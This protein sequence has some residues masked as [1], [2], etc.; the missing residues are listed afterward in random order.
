MINFGIV[1]S[2]VS[3]L[4][5]EHYVNNQTDT[6]EDVFRGYMNVVKQSPVLMSQYI[7]FKNLE[8]KDILKEAAAK[9]IDDNINA[10]KRYSREEIIAENNKLRQFSQGNLLQESELHNAIQTLIIESVPSKRMPDVNKLYDSFLVVQESVCSGDYQTPEY[11]NEAIENDDFT[12]Q[13]VMTAASKNFNDEYRHL[14]EEEKDILQVLVQENEKAQKNLLN[15]LKEQAIAYVNG[16][17]NINESVK[18]MTIET[19]RDMT[20]SKDSI[21]EDI[22]HLHELMN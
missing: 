9:Y 12:L 8:R 16:Q 22:I 7:V 5:G 20:Y 4:L 21:V 10:M 19:L 13:E 11:L 2:Q 3:Q 1:K 14:T 17:E 15:Q 18:Q 6:A